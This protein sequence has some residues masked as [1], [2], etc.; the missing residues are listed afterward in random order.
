[1]SHSALTT[2]AGPPGWADPGF[3]GRLAYIRTSKDNAIPDFAQDGMMAGSGVTWDVHRFDTGHSP[4]LSQP[5]ALS[6]TI[7][8]L[9]EAWAR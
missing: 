1:M 8:G 3:S 7:L 4:F 2:P 6:K 9:A 5:D